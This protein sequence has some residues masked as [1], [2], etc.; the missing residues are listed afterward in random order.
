MKP[1]YEH[2]I[3][4]SWCHTIEAMKC[5]PKTTIASNNLSVF[6]PIILLFFYIKINI[7]K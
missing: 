1:Q 5:N 7:K 2:G 4:R 3:N 6:S